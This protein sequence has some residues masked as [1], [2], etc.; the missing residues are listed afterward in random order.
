[1]RKSSL[2]EYDESMNG[3]YIDLNH[4]DY[5]INSNN[6][7]FRQGFFVILTGYARNT[8]KAV[9]YRRDSDRSS[10]GFRGGRGGAAGR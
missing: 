5:S 7:C 3:Y 9:K 8:K 6:P 2:F 4:A 10:G 1:M